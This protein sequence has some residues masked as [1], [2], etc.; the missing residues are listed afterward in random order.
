MGF[1]QMA[2]FFSVLGLII[3]LT[4]YLFLKLSGQYDNLTSF[5]QSM[6]RLFLVILL[7][8]NVLNVSFFIIDNNIMKKEADNKKINEAEQFVNSIKKELPRTI[9]EKT[10]LTNVQLEDNNRIVFLF[11][12]DMTKSDFEKVF[13]IIENRVINPWCDKYTKLKDKSSGFTILYNDKRN[14]YLGQIEIN[15]EVCLKD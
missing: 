5:Q 12:V 4:G 8:L 15:E 7:V 1:E 6:M 13:P 11:I 9:D 14:E 2:V 10:V 3:L